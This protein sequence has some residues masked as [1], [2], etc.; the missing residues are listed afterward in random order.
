MTQ[1]AETRMAMHDLNLLSNYDVPEHWKE[2]E[3]RR[4]GGFAVYD[5]ERYVVDFETIC[6]VSD[7]RS[8][9]VCVGYDNNFVAS[10]N[11]FLEVIS[12]AKEVVEY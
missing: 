11:E 3:H 10:I 1:V 12:A 6:K 8:A 7:A 2:R 5:E 9:G 4:K